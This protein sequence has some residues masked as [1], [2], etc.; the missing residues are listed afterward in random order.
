MQDLLG[1]VLGVNQA[2]GHGIVPVH[3]DGGHQ[4]VI[5]GAG[6][7]DR[8]V[9]KVEGLVAVAPV[10]GLIGAGDHVD[11]LPQV[12]QH[13]VK[14]RDGVQSDIRVLDAALVEKQIPVTFYYG[15]YIGQEFTDVPAAGMWAASI[16]RLPP[17]KGSSTTIRWFS[18]PSATA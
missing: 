2:V 16:G 11:A 17:P 8:Q 10:G 12:V 14:G 15:D 7:T 5:F 3:R 13:F 18:T 9:P 4:G 6:H 1:R